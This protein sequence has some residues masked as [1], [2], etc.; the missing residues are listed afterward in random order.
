MKLF[1]SEMFFGLDLEGITSY[2]QKH[3]H[4]TI[5]V[6]ARKALHKQQINKKIIYEKLYLLH[7]VPPVFN[8]NNLY[9]NDTTLHG[10]T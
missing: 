3:F 1:Y 5:I 9:Q 2:G 4:E 7:A 10:M 6:C 8:S